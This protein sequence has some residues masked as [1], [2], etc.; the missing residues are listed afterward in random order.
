MAIDYTTLRVYKCTTFTFITTHLSITGVTGTSKS[1]IYV[2]L[3]YAVA[4]GTETVRPYE[5][6]ERCCRISRWPRPVWWRQRPTHHRH[7]A[8]P[9]DHL[10]ASTTLY[11]KL[12]C[13]SLSSDFYQQLFLTNSRYLDWFDQSRVALKYQIWWTN[14]LDQFLEIISLK[15]DSVPVFIRI[16]AD[17]D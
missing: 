3:S 17:V 4:L 8:P 9:P 6:E 5:E 15:L 1:Q 2:G 10:H 14:A 7:L 16:L 12:I 11:L 13:L